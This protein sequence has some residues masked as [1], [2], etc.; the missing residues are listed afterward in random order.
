MLIVALVKT[1]HC[2]Q[3]DKETNHEKKK[4]LIK[5]KKEQFNNYWRQQGQQEKSNESVR[6]WKCQEPLHHKMQKRVAIHDHVYQTKCSG[7]RKAMLPP[8]ET[9]GI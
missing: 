4:Q 7:Q 2:W 6:W 8:K 9:L 1:V 5:Y 3:F